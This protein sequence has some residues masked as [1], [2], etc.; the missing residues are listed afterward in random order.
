MF[1]GSA[2]GRDNIY[3]F[4]SKV[5]YYIMGANL[6]CTN[7]INVFLVKLK[8]LN[9]APIWHINGFKHVNDHVYSL[10]VPKIAMGHKT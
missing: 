5:H 6:L 8:I 1:M 3:V 10:P 9:E 2:N 7:Y 4:I